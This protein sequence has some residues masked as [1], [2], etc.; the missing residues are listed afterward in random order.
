MKY[1]K[2]YKI[3]ESNFN[4]IDNWDTLTK[5][6]KKGNLLRLY[7]SIS[8][9]K[10]KS[11]QVINYIIKNIKGKLYDINETYQIIDFDDINEWGL[12]NK[13]RFHDYFNSLIDNKDT[14]G[15]N[16]EGTIAGLF[17]GKLSKNLDSRYD[18]IIDNIYYSIK[19]VD[20][21]NES[22][23]LGSI[24]DSIEECIVIIDNDDSINEKL[25]KYIINKL[26]T[27][28]IHEFF[29][30]DK[31]PLS[32]KQLIFDESYKNVN[33]F[34]L[35][36]LLDNKIIVNV[37]NKIDMRNYICNSKLLLAP[38]SGNYSLR[39]NKF[40][41]DNLT[42]S[43]FEI[44]IP[45]ITNEELDKLRDIE[46]LKIAKDIFGYNISKKL[47]PDVIDDIIKNKDYIFKNL[48]D[49]INNS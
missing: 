28:K 1:I 3:F 7:A 43:R 13:L 25:K 32:E 15:F 9:H 42:T 41:Y 48:S 44:I 39:I 21:I 23:S 31:I 30:D 36:Y 17:G 6:Q 46:S 24:K 10:T 49:F 11:S 37:I 19:F 8:T 5:E 16:F 20:N 47:R 34:I 29:N 35:G 22:I 33:M 2:S 40:I 38:K 12:H 45:E 26:E 4:I 27:K 14:R 18:I